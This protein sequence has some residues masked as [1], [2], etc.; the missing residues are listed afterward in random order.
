MTI[1][2]ALCWWSLIGMATWFMKV[3]IYFRGPANCVEW[4]IHLHE[5]KHGKTPT[6]DLIRNNPTPL[7]IWG[8]IIYS[9]FGPIS[10]LDLFGVI[11]SVN[12]ADKHK[13]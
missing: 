2:A 4:L 6:T 12:A 9:I 8:L 7:L 3:F 11:R 1:L 10:V 5:Q 13:K